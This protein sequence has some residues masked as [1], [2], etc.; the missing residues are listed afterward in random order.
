MGLSASKELGLLSE[1]NEIEASEPLLSELVMKSYPS[2]FDGL[3][4]I[5]GRYRITL[6]DDA[7]PVVRGCVK[8]PYA[9]RDRVKEAIDNAVKQRVLVKQNEPTEWVNSFSWVEKP[10]GTIRLCLDPRPLNKAIMREHFAMPTRDDLVVDLAGAKY[11]T[12]LDANSAFWQIQLDYE[13][14]LLTTFNTPWGRYRFKR[15]PY[16]ISSASEHYQRRLSYM[17]E[18]INGVKVSH[19]DILIYANTRAMHDKILFE[20]LDVLK[21]NKVTLNKKKCVFAVQSL[22]FM[23]ETITADGILPDP[24]KIKA[25]KDLKP[26]TNK[27]ELLRFMG[28]INFLARHIPALSEK[29]KCLRE[30]LLKKKPWEW[31]ISQHEAW[32]NLKE[33]ICKSPILAHYDPNK[34][35]KVSADASRHALGAVLLQYDMNN[36]KPIAYASRAL[37]TTEQRYAQIELEL[38]A[39]FFACNKFDQFLLGKRFTVESDHKPLITL[40]GK[41]LFSCPLRAQRLMLSLQRFDFHIEFVP[42]KFLYTADVLSR[43]V[44]NTP[45]IVQEI[46][47]ET[48]PPCV[49]SMHQQ[50]KNELSENTKHD[51]VLM[52]LSDYIINGWP[53]YIS[54]CDLEL[55]QYWPMKNELSVQY[56][57]IFRGNRVVIPSLLR[58]KFLLELHEGHLGQNKCKSKAR[59]LL[60]WPG[61]S[62]DIDNVVIACDICSKYSSQQQK[63]PLLPHPVPKY[64]YDRVGLDIF[65]CDT[66][67]YLIITDY[68]SSFPEVFPLNRTT[69]TALIN[70]L[71]PNF[72]R[73]GY[74]VTLVSDGAPN[75]TSEEFENF[76]NQSCITHV[77]SSAYFPQSNGMVEKSVQTCKK[78]ITKA[79]ESNS[80]IFKALHA[81]RTSP[82]ACGL[83]PAQLFFRRRLRGTLPICGQL[84]ETST[85]NFS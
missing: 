5:P 80:D 4:C 38:L 29:T 51:P 34:P 58:H 50:M 18:S 63:E 76:L 75:L 79:N 70:A 62:Q 23:G 17:L 25:I 54:D 7:T 21:K 47:L 77:N 45:Q 31:G 19:D 48:E 41:D 84:L 32:L 37:T 66:K 65:T 10:D 55:K 1:A 12:K 82:L 52:K 40:F 81:Y 68:F 16:G 64:P 61:M 72:S 74:P 27:T 67:D 83:S 6:Q 85:K 24:N 30:L 2:L 49:D 14:S 9:K 46:D 39:I 26:P 3:G 53:K 35:I 8:I 11:F 33:M 43:F 60:Y 57:I 20:V 28:M 15:M 56:G 73:Y 44:Q 71:K 42:G 13:S 36:W 78:L 59:E 69:S 22:L